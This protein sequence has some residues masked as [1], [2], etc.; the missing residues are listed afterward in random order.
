LI[1]DLQI[2]AS[3][4]EGNAASFFGCPNLKVA[5]GSFP[6]YVNFSRSGIKKLGNLEITAPNKDKKKANFTGCNIHLPEKFLGP[7]YQ[8]DDGIRRKNLGRIAASNALDA[9]PEMEI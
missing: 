5:E 2:K 7:E 4:E 3:D 1:G 8:M 6:G 9:Q